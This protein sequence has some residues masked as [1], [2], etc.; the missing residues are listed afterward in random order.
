MERPSVRS[1]F[2]PRCA[3][4][5]AS[6]D[7]K[8]VGPTVFGRRPLNSGTSRMEVLLCGAILAAC[9]GGI[10]EVPVAFVST[11]LSPAI[12]QLAPDCAPQGGL[13][14]FR[15]TANMA[16]K[17]QGSGFVPESVVR[18]NG[19]D[20]PTTFINAF[21]L[22]AELQPSDYAKVGTAAVTVYTP[23]LGGAIS[24]AMTFTVNSGGIA[25][26]S[27]T[28]DPSGNFA[29]VPND[30]CSLNS[31]GNISMYSIDANTGQLKSLGPPVESLIYGAKSIAISS[32][33]RFAYAVVA[34]TG[35]DLGFV[36]TYTVDPATGSLAGQ[37]TN[38]GV[39]G[40]LPG[41]IALAPSGKLALVADANGY[42]GPIHIHSVDPVSGLLAFVGDTGQSGTGVSIIIDGAGRYAYS[43][44]SAGISTYGLDAPLGLRFIGPV[45]AAGAAVGAL[46]SDGRF[47]YV[48]SNNGIS[49][50]AVDGAS[51]IPTLAGTF[52]PGAGAVA[53][54]LHPSNR[55]AYAVSAGS[56]T[57]F[58]YR[59]ETNTGSLDYL[60]AAATD[61]APSSIAIAP[62]GNF[63]YVTNRNANSVSVYSVDNLT[64]MLTFIGAIGT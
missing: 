25:P 57:V 32:D 45:P 50:Y 42:H 35:D 23:A 46:S 37:S 33:R 12:S 18:W 16:L 39:D 19:S 14:P 27:I 56:N 17:I 61:S 4:A 49:V 58:I 54:A 63:A 20:R 2:Q 59:I 22:Q 31:S 44:G 53:M 21:V 1:W 8:Q 47:L 28:I 30:G 34:G 52:T 24:N 10:N 36:A 64:G 15:P 26:N 51:G 5:A 62:S 6:M 11:A 41:S 13:S 55:F 38:Y 9:G 43:F 29:Y 48:P 3:A 60:G 40:T 7:S